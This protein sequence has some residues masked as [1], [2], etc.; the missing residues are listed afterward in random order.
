MG[1]KYLARKLTS[2]FVWLTSP[3]FP[4]GHSSDEHPGPSPTVSSTAAWCRRTTP[5]R[6]A[7]DITEAAKE[8]HEGES[9][10]GRRRRVTG[11][12]SAKRNSSRGKSAKESHGS[13]NRYLMGPGKIFEHPTRMWRFGFRVEDLYLGVLRMR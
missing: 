12:K 11:G 13:A 7:P 10:E 8:S 2:E 3:P 1:G 5:R 9:G 4:L 6:G